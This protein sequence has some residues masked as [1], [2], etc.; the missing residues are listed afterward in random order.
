MNKIIKCI[1]L[2]L[3]GTLLNSGPD[4]L[5]ALNYVLEKQNL[6]II[7]KNIIGSLV[8][9]GAKAM[10]ERAYNFLNKKIP[11]NKM[12]I[13]INCFLDFYSE[14]CSKSS[15]LYPNVENTIK[16]LK[17]KF[18][19][20]LCT[21]KKQEISEKILKEF[22]IHE[23]FDL[24]LGSSKKHKLKPSAEMLEYCLKKL[25]VEPEETIMIGDSINDIIPAQ[26][27]GV[28]TIFVNYGY[29]KLDNSIKPN[30]KVNSFEEILQ[31]PDIKF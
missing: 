12:E 30:H 27:I 25:Q 3:D 21:N 9:G 26:K 18:K 1:V 23:F 15:H 31:V 13:L 6:K 29:G 16:C 11:S 5:L 4:L 8:G 10:I 17:K 7:N 14:N 28:K 22:K 2:D 19:I 20:A 24:V